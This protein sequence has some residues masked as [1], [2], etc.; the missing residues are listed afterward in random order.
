MIL[1]KNSFGCALNRMKI[2]EITNNLLPILQKIYRFVDSSIYFIGKTDITD[3]TNNS[4]FIYYF[5]D[6]KVTSF[7]YKVV[8]DFVKVIPISKDRRYFIEKSVSHS[9][10]GLFTL[11]LLYST[12]CLY[13]CNY[14]QHCQCQFRKVVFPC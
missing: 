8:K 4:N 12:L 10:I 2:L 5:T 1:I 13:S 11:P 14:V 9:L 3:L 6:L 7:G